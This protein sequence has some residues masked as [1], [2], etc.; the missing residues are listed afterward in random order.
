MR[1]VSTIT[2][3]FIIVTGTSIA[4]IQALAKYIIETVKEK[5]I[6]PIRNFDNNWVLLD[7]GDFIV[8]LFLEETR[9]YYGLEGLWAD[10]PR[11]SK[12]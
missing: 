12:L 2:D 1:K 5:P 7:F 3:Y 10:A 6:N 9:N 11:I 8:H 4:H